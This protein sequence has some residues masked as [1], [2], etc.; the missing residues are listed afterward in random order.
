[1][2]LLQPQ[3]PLSMP[4]TRLQLVVLIQP[5]P[6]YSQSLKRHVTSDCAA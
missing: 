1:M 3:L 5:Q 4:Q 2:L 6:A